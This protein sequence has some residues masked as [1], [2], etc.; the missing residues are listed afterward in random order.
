MAKYE[1]T[2]LSFVNN[3]L[4]EAGTIVEVNDDP[5]K[6]GMKPGSNMKLAKA[7]AVASGDADGNDG[8]K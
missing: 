4:V 2:E 8:D 3:R 7:G 6:G 5:K 1:V